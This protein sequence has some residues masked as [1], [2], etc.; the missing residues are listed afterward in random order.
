MKYL[1]DSRQNLESNLQTT[2]GRC[3]LFHGVN[4]AFDRHWDHKNMC[5]FADA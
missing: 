5:N 4:V 2:D 1:P 3:Y